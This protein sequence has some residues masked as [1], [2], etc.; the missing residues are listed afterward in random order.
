MKLNALVV[1]AM[2]ITS[3]NAAGKGGLLSCFGGICGSGKSK[4]PICVRNNV[5][6]FTL[7]DKVID[8]DGEFQEQLP[9]FYN[10][11]TMGEGED[12]KGKRVK[13]G[14][15]EE[16]VEE[17]EKI[18]SKDE[19]I[20]VW[21]ESHPEAIPDLRKIKSKYDMLEKER[22]K[23]WA[24]LGNNECMNGGFKHTSLKELTR[25]GYLPKWYDENGVD[26]LGEY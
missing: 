12:E 2:V 23:I 1:A 13:K 11:I 9:S 14:K 16:K 3:V 19:Q 21:L 8:L 26:F 24:R 5:K 20:R 4:D 10:I 17:K 6:L 7:W 22:C 25:R 15:K 18:N